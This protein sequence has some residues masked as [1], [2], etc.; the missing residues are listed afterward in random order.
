MNKNNS[1]TQQDLRAGFQVVL[2]VAET[3]REVGEA[4][5]SIISTGL[6]TKGISFESYKSIIRTLKNSGLVEETTGGQI[7][8]WTGPFK[9]ERA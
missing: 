4:P 8:R 6:Q 1:I 3:I 5:A 7:L 9:G 2:A